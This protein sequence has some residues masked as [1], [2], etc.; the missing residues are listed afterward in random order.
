MP[1]LARLKQ[2]H[3]TT[4]SRSELPPL[5]F[6]V[7]S[8]R[9][10]TTLLRAMLD[11]HPEIAVTPESLFLPRFVEDR[12][13]YE[14]PEGLDVE[15]FLA[16]L[17]GERGFRRLDVP[18]EEL[19]VALA[20]SGART[21]Q[22]AVRVLYLR[23]ARRQG[24]ER[25]GDKTPAYARHVG[26]IA[27]LLPEACFLQVVRDGR[28]V[29]LSYLDM[30]FG[31]AGV[32]EAALLWRELVESARDAGHALGSDR[33]MEIRYEDLIEDPEAMLRSVCDLV[34]LE[35]H[36][37]MLDYPR[38]AGEL[39][40]A[41]GGAARHPG[42]FQ[43]PTKGLRDWRSELAGPAVEAFE[44]TA[45]DLLAELGY[46]RHADQVHAPSE[47]S[48]RMLVDELVA[49]RRRITRVEQSRRRKVRRS[50]A[51]QR[52]AGEARQRAERRL[53]RLKVRSLGAVEAQTRRRYRAPR[54]LLEMLRRV[55]LGGIARGRTRA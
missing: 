38:R 39:V 41:E 49:Q 45:G 11:S 32:V 14:S 53:E 17:G 4:D 55:T 8:G 19:R 7:G 2:P 36:D 30:P 23:Y 48:V 29:A 31:P 43:A 15:R 42:V 1:A 22:D 37:A 6:I 33:Y 25:C 3:V 13:R 54:R 10:G 21:L 26:A 27:E 5:P 44:L 16:D 40:A 18:E 9:S 51:R 46:E 47:E 12:R 20:D 34:G 50:R 52:Q 35:F 28:N 24:K